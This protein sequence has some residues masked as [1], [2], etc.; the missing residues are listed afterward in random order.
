MAQAG[1]ADTAVPPAEGAPVWVIPRRQFLSVEYP[2]IVQADAA[3]LDRALATL[4]PHVGPVEGMQS[5]QSALAHL[6]EVLELGGRVVECRLAP[7]P[8]ARKRSSELEHFR[9][10]V[11]GDIADTDALIVRLHRR[12]WRRCPPGG[13]E[14]YVREYTVELLG[15]CGKAVRFRRMAD[16]GFRP[17][18]PV[19]VAR[20]G[21]NPSIEL[22]KALVRMDVDAMR[23]FR[24]N[25]EEE[26]Y[27]RVENGKTHSNVG[28]G[29]PPFFSRVELPFAYNYRQNPA[30]SLH[31][32]PHSSSVKRARRTARKGE[33]DMQ[34]DAAEERII[35]RYVSRS[36]WRSTAPIATK[37][38][39]AANVPEK[40]DPSLEH[41]PL[42]PR[43]EALL[44][45]LRELL[46]DRP[47]WSR[48]SLVNQFTAEDARTLIQTKELFALATYTFAD[49][50]WR[51][52]LVRF[53]YDPRRDAESRFYQRIHLRGKPSRTPPTRRAFKAEYG[54]V[55]QGRGTAENGRDAPGGRVRTSHIFDG[56]HAPHASST[57]QLC[58]ITDVTIVPLVQATG[59][60]NLREEPDIVTGWYTTQAWD[61]IRAAIS[62]RFRALLGDDTSSSAAAADL[63]DAYAGVGNDGASEDESGASDDSAE[64][65]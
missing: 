53:G 36:R 63:Q 54:A 6:A 59:R 58:D 42:S 35:T 48:L 61:A 13:E 25:P 11:L 7:P 40:P 52:S 49:G 16:F 55:P 17:E 37:F 65:V 1:A 26:V 20:P 38:G 64:E 12:V 22:H 14:Q 8:A 18:P 44:I 5:A 45:K 29:P 21:A 39:D 15:S 46:Q 2:G 23:N 43:H 27:T 62:A 47:V 41:L 24:F 34:G 56:K 4:S 50:P 60:T 51:D 57:F 32:L 31:T 19:S 28:M 33:A 10:P 3:S 30:S 9:H